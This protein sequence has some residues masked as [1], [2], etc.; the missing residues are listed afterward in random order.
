MMEIK[1]YQVSFYVP[2]DDPASH[3]DTFCEELQEMYDRSG[4]SGWFDIDNVVEIQVD[5]G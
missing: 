2:M 1:K 4:M 3:Q 5:E